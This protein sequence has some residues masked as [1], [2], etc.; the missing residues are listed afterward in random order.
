MKLQWWHTS[1][2]AALSLS[3]SPRPFASKFSIWVAACQLTRL[4]AG[5]LVISEDYSLLLPS[6]LQHV[7]QTRWHP[8]SLFFTFLHG[9]IFLFFVIHDN[10]ALISNEFFA[11]ACCCWA[12]YYV[13]R[14]IIFKLILNVCWNI[15]CKYNLIF[16]VQSVYVCLLYCKQ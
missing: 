5:N 7:V 3:F 1:E 14:V 6:L 9:L 8:V 16:M 15:K 12:M 10:A 13:A 2:S 11:H 4:Q